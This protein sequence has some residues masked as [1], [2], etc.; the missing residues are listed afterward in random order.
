MRSRARGISRRLSRQQD[1]QAATL[2]YCLSPEC[3]PAAQPLQAAYR[4]SH[5]LAG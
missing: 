4:C 3:S 1:D 2:L 5:V